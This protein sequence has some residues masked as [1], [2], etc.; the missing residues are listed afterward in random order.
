MTLRASQK[1]KVQKSVHSHLASPLHNVFQWVQTTHAYI[2]S[3][4]GVIVSV[5]LEKKTLQPLHTNDIQSGCK[6]LNTHT[7][8]LCSN[9]LLPTILR[10]SFIIIYPHI[11]LWIFCFLFISI[12]QN[13]RRCPTL[14]LF[15]HLKRSL[16]EKCFPTVTRH[17]RCIPRASIG[18]EGI[19]CFCVT[20]LVLFWGA[21]TWLNMS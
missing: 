5:I 10:Y 21:K 20:K 9:H 19:S 2:G 17:R 15:W 6:T 11:G 16:F 3:V 18:H 4:I 1:W 12:S 8:I 7:S 13:V 14:T